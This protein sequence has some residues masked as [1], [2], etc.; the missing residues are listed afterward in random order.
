[1]SDTPR[2]DKGCFVAV[3]ENGIFCRPA[4]ARELE[5]DLAA[6]N[7]RAERAERMARALAYKVSIYCPQN[8]CCGRRFNQFNEHGKAVA[9]EDCIECQLEKAIAK[10]GEQQ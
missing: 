4:V 9:D 10:E 8:E 1:M 2:T 6:A 5:R 3:M 7:A